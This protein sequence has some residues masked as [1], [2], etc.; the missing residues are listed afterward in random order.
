M[1][2]RLRGNDGSRG[3]QWTDKLAVA[4]RHVAIT[5][6]LDRRC[7]SKLTCCRPRRLSCQDTSPEGGITATVTFLRGER[8]TRTRALSLCRASA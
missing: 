4:S 6:T 3:G 8:A 7:D 2:F 5:L 1:D